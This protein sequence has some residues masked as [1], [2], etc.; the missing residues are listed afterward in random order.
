[1]DAHERK[2][3]YC[4]V[5]RRASDALR[6]KRLGAHERR[7]LL[8]AAV[9]GGEPNRIHPPG[10][11]PTEQTA[12]RRAVANLVGTGLLRLASERIRLLPGHDDRELARLGRK[13]ANRRPKK[14]G[15]SFVFCP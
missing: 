14:V 15:G 2:C 3:E 6:F 4:R 12:T 10:S 9:P 13:Y 7:Q 5:V 1:M 8:D 11:S